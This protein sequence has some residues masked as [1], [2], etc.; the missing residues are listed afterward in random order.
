MWQY[1]RGT[2][3]ALIEHNDEYAPKSLFITRDGNTFSKSALYK[4]CVNIGRRV[5]A[6]SN[7]HILRHSFA[8]YWLLA[9]PPQHRQTA[10]LKL[11]AVLG[12]NSISTTEIYLHLL[13][14]ISNETMASYQSLVSQLFEE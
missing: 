10:L 9:A 2:R 8:T 4:A 3:N 14:Q 6:H 1:S 12:H 7:P 11:K 13:D 5:G